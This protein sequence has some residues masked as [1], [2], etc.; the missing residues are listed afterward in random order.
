M[1]VANAIATNVYTTAVWSPSV[2]VV[3]SVTEERLR[4]K[5][6]STMFRIPFLYQVN[7]SEV[8]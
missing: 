7:P 6:Y 1:K 8:I 3:N 5:E 4:K 2:S